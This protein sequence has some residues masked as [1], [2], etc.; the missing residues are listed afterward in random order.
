[1][2]RVTYSN[3]LDALV[4]RFLERSRERLGSFP[5]RVFAKTIVIVPNRGVE[6]YLRYEIARRIG[7]AAN[8]EF[9][10]LEA[11]VSDLLRKIELN[12]IGLVTG[13]PAA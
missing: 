5:Q 10:F 3:H 4:E 13:K 11:Y 2:L 6:T 1:M 12:Q 7:I 8:L 9:R